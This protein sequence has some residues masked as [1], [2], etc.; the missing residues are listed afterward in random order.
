MGEIQGIARFK[1]HDG[2]LEEWKRL[3][4]EAMETVRSKDSGTLQYD[5][6]L[7]AT[8]IPLTGASGAMVAPTA[9]K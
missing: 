2:R 8:P 3:T 1:I 6:F 9:V 4:A 7:S 5:F